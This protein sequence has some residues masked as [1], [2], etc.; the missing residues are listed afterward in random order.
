MTATIQ[1]LFGC[2][3]VLSE[4]L[5]ATHFFVQDW[6]SRCEPRISRAWIIAPPPPPFP[7][8]RPKAR[9]TIAS[10]EPG[11]DHH[12]DSLRETYLHSRPSIYL[13]KKDLAGPKGEKG[14]RGLKGETGVPG[15]IGAEGIGGPPGLMGPP[16]E[17]VVF[18]IMR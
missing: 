12:R 5:L 11:A 14:S 16:G 10:E 7:P 4:Q 1:L 13:R 15:P 17:K 2:A 3:A 6:A 9:F 18:V 8:K